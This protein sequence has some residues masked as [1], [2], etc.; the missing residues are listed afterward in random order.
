MLIQFTGDYIF[1][2]F[3]PD[4]GFI[5]LICFDHAVDGAGNVLIKDIFDL[6]EGDPLKKVIYQDSLKGIHMDI[7]DGQ[8][9]K[10]GRM[11][12]FIM[13]ILFIHVNFSYLDLGDY[14]M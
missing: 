1:V 6:H 8:D 5:K 13:Y 9:N 12:I 11:E 4:D 3:L 2:K 14:F 10:K 7:Q